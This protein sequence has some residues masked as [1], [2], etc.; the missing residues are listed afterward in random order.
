[1]SEMLHLGTKEAQ[2]ETSAPTFG[3][4]NFDKFGGAIPLGDLNL[5][6]PV[7]GDAPVM[8][9]V[10]FESIENP[11][12]R[13]LMNLNL[14]G[15]RESFELVDGK[16]RPKYVP[17][18]DRIKPPQGRTDF[19]WDAEM[20]RNHLRSAYGR[21]W[22]QF[23]Y[24]FRAHDGVLHLVGGGPSLKDNIKALRRYSQKPKNF[25]LSVNK[26]HDFLFDLPKHKLGP[27]IK[28]WGAALLDPC[29]WVKDYITPRPGVQYLIGD[30][31]AP[32][33]FDVFE[34]PELTK[35]VWRATNPAKDQD[36]VPKGMAF[37]YG[38]STVGLRMRTMGYYMGFREIHYWG[39][40]SSAEITPD[41]PDGKMHG[42]HKD[43]SVKDR[44]CV[45]IMDEKGFEKEFLTNT[46][47]ARQADEFTEVFYEW[48][49]QFR[50]GRAEW[51]KDVFHGDGLLPTVAARMGLHADP[52]RNF[53]EGM[54]PLIPSAPDPLLYGIGGQT[55]AT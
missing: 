15:V 52:E 1:M 55:H 24:G 9:T 32:A 18:R 34:K 25:V 21:G 48:V 36:I 51:I 30:Q 22:Q 29:A 13:D 2:G 26:T 50:T 46:H 20:R 6:L 49:K 43:E 23:P 14:P 10:C 17:L 53:T 44:V 27:P 16:I 38:G 41:R 4:P 5:N 39:F 47:M 35:W 37:V 42:Y 7:A 19:G 8:G 11:T 33:T 31:C 40:D 28:S 12:P 3:M 54:V 45:K